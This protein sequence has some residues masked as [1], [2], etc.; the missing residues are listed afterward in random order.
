MYDVVCRSV[1]P[2]TEH[3]ASNNRVDGVNYDAS[4]NLAGYRYDA[5]SRITLA[6]G[7]CYLYDAEGR[8]VA[9]STYLMGEGL[10]GIFSLALW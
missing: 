2:T 8:R 1:G 9:K 6:E 7:V 10:K 5:A 3:C 4:G